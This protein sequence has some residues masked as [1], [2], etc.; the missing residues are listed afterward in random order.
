[1]VTTEFW[2][3]W[4]GNCRVLMCRTRDQENK[5]SGERLWVSG[6]VIQETECEILMELRERDR[7]IEESKDMVSTVTNSR[8]KEQPCLHLRLGSS[9]IMWY[10]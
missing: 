8:V 2:C 4:Q 6:W 3:V 5:C 10:Q 9:S 7:L 1:M